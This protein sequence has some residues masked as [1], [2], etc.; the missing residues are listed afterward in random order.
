MA[1]NGASFWRAARADREGL[2]ERIAQREDARDLEE[3]RRLLYVALTRAR[4]RLRRLMDPP[5]PVATLRRIR[6]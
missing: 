6:P 4:E 3:R 2:T 1:A 5:T